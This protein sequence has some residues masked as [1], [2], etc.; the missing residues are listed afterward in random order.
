M[1]LSSNLVCR[2]RVTLF[3]TVSGVALRRRGVA[4]VAEV[5][6]EVAVQLGVEILI[7]RALLQSTSQCF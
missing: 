3:A 1:A 2:R 7:L 4:A 5:L 6:D